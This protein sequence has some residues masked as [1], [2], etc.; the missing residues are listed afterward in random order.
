[1]EIFLWMCILVSNKLRFESKMYLYLF[2]APFIQ[3]YLKTI[4][5]GRGV[6]GISVTQTNYIT[7]I[8]IAQTQSL[9]VKNNSC[10]WEEGIIQIHIT[11]ASI[12]VKSAGRA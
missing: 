6:V 4:Q 5:K 3:S 12:V 2:I 8:A 10:S 11:F 9:E 7:A 1:M